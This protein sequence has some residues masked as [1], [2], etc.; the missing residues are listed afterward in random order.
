MLLSYSH[1]GVDFRLNSGVS[2]AVTETVRCFF[3]NPSERYCS[4]LKV[5]SFLIFRP[6]PQFTGPPA[7]SCLLQGVYPERLQLRDHLQVSDQV[8]L[9]T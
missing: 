3:S 1:S 7:A 8:P 2:L 9:R 6:D 4:C 5:K